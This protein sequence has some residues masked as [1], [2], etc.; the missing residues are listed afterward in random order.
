MSSPEGIALDQAPD[1]RGLSAAE[2]VERVERGQD[3]A[4][5]Q[6]SSRSLAHILRANVLTR[7]NAL[8]GGL[9]VV[10]IVVGPVQD[11]LFGF[12]LVA[13]TA[14][15][16]IQELRAKRTLDRLALVA[17]PKARV[18]RDGELGELPVGEVVLDDVLD[19]Q[20]GDQ[21]VVDGLVLAGEL[22]VDESLVS[23]EAEPATK[24]PGA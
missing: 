11:A 18:V 20:A 2:V 9:L 8:L 15:G 19:L 6:P 16:I 3:N 24:A 12:V 7:F 10:I 14:I 13:N 21:I 22:E 5:P 1:L 17:A 23:G 4:Q